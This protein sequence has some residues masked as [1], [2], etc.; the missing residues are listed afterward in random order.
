MG[1]VTMNVLASFTLTTAIHPSLQKTLNHQRKSPKPS[2]KRFL[3]ALCFRLASNPQ[4]H[5]STKQIG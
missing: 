4:T 3:M 5:P 2:L 1:C